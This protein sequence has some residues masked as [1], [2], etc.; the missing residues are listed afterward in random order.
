MY[1]RAMNL[2]LQFIFLVFPFCL[3]SGAEQGKRERSVD[4]QTKGRTFLSF[5]QPLTLI[6]DFAQLCTA[7]GIK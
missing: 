2:V 6:D 1:K 4:S 7:Q 5:S 3:P